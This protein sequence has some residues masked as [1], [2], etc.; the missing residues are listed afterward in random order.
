MLQDHLRVYRCP[1]GCP[2]HFTSVAESRSHLSRAHSGAIPESKV[3]SIVDLSSQPLARDAH[4]DCPF[5][6][7]KLK[8]LKQYRRHVGNHQQD[9]ALFALP[10][11]KD[12][13]DDSEGRDSMS[14]HESDDISFS[15]YDEEPLDT[16]VQNQETD[17][18]TEGEESVSLNF[19]DASPPIIREFPH[20]LDRNSLASRDFQ[21]S[22]TRSFSPSSRGEVRNDQLPENMSGDLPPPRG[23]TTSPPRYVPPWYDEPLSAEFSEDETSPINLDH[24]S[25]SVVS[26]RERRHSFDRGQG[27]HPAQRPLGE[28]SSDDD[29]VRFEGSDTIEGFK[30]ISEAHNIEAITR[31]KRRA[32]F[33]RDDVDSDV[34][35][36]FLRERVPSFR[37]PIN[38]CRNCRRRKVSKCANHHIGGSLTKNTKIPCLEDG[39]ESKCRHCNQEGLECTTDGI[40]GSASYKTELLTY[41]ENQDASSQSP[42]PE[43]P[44]E[45][46]DADSEKFKAKVLYNFAGKAANEMTARNG[47]LVD[48]LHQNDN[49]KTLSHLSDMHLG[50]N[51]FF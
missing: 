42:L 5:C 38:A 46:A 48:I 51:S 34:A 27:E 36:R 40:P 15:E 1:F 31:N 24:S 8:S 49:G 35:E 25:N 2:E 44:V 9:L 10:P 7:E 32:F 3:D 30:D 18:S 50:N 19:E 4:T 45:A 21:V 22:P 39:L 16:T 14:G 33:L 37:I 6:P 43:V 26:S 23:F 41:P 13:D 17:T 28:T 47:D 20:D 12:G 29:R 11:T